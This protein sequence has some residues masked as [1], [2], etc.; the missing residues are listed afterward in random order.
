MKAK[1]LQAGGLIA[2]LITI[3]CLSGCGGVNSQKLNDA[4]NRINAL[5]SKGVAD[6][7][8]SD[9]RMFLYNAATQNKI[10]N[11]PM[12]KKY[13]DSL[14]MNLKKLEG[15]QQASSTA[16]KPVVESMLSSFKDKKKELSGYQLKTADAM[17]TNIESLLSQGRIG[18]AK[19]NGQKL[20]DLL[21]NLLADE[22]KAQNAKKQLVGTW[23]SVRKPE[24]SPFKATETRV[25]KFGGDGKVTVSE[26][27]TG[28]TSPTLKEDWKFF[29]EGTWDVSGD[30]ALLSISREQRQKL[31]TWNLED[32]G[33]KQSWV[34]REKPSYD[35]TITDSRKDK[36]MT[37]TDITKDFDKKK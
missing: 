32:K 27:F 19:L 28:Q 14:T 20:T 34:K 4:Q 21:P 29:S 6:S 24:G 23:T 31:V 26:Q 11:G 35:S 12:A 16:D 1:V 25:L 37:L 30:T 13:F 5:Q 33:G 17:I 7:L 22:Q 10:G 3:V 15:N 36:W 8:L 9:A 2:V 18:E